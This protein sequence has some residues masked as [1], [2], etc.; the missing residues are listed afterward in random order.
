MDKFFDHPLILEEG[1]QLC[2]RDLRGERKIAI[3]LDNNVVKRVD[4][5]GG[6]E[7]DGSVF[8]SFQR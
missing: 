5:N 1:Y 8:G 2:K 4:V 7:M 6:L 3:C